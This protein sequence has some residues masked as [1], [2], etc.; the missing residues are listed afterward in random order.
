MTKKRAGFTLLELL[1]AI[2]IIV[3]IVGM[4]FTSYS[5]AQ[6]KA[7]DA[8]RK[9]DLK[10]IQNSLEQYYSVCG[11]TYPNPATGNIVPTIVC[12]TPPAINILTTPSK[13]PKSGSDYTMTG[14]GS[15]YSVC[16][17]N[18]PPLETEGVASYC[19]SNQQ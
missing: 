14:G 15:S 17:P 19:L 11:Y 9:S 4:G 8:V 10:A 18:S 5:T 1:V 7:R 13:D 6:K 12:T 3:L 16:A 2:G